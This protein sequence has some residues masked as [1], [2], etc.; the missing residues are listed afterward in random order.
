MALVVLATLM[1]LVGVGI[2]VTPTAD[3]GTN[4]RLRSVSRPTAIRIAAALT[5]GML[6]V[7]MSGWLVPGVV[8][9]LGAFW[10]AR[11]GRHRGR[12]IDVEVAR[13]DALATWIESVRDVLLAGEQPI[14]AIT[15]SVAACPSI[16]RTPVRRLAVALGRQDPD[17]AFRRFA[18]D[19]DDPVG[20][21]VATGLSIAVRRGART[22]PVLTALAEQTRQQADRR[23]L[24]E[25]ERAP[26]R[27]E[28]QALTAIMGSLVLGLVVLGRSE[29]LDAYDH[30]AGQLFLG[31]ALAAYAAL[32]VRVQRLAAFP[33]PAR[34]L[35][36]G[37]VDDPDV[38]RAMA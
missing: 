1:L 38:D 14:G 37:D 16:I 11:G 17:L 7:A 36:A 5:I 30:P 4:G 10:V 6:V 19:I 31:S 12:A 29:Y 33:R 13:L 32:I 27:R 26:T 18:D 22:V 20:D 35:T 8:V 9:A 28:V 2:A 23:R 34:F 24:I 21:L 3:V 15:S 25:A